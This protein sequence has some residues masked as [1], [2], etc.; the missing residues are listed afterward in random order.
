MAG[1]WEPGACAPGAEQEPALCR[2]PCPAPEAQASGFFQALGN[3]FL[4][5]R[6]LVQVSR[7]D[8]GYKRTAVR[9][10]PPKIVRSS[11]GEPQVAFATAK[12]AARHEALPEAAR[13]GA[14]LIS[15]CVSDGERQIAR[16]ALFEHLPLVAM[17]NKDFSKLEKPS[18]RHFEACAA[19]NKL[20]CSPPRRHRRVGPRRRRQPNLSTFQLFNLLTCK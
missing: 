14:A 9:G 11:V 7:R 8:F 15:P 17:R 18:G 2:A 20:P 1:A 19:I 12:Y 3:H 16:E 5:G 6:P 10:G 13:R 4:L